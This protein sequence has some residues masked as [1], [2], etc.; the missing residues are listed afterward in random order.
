MS[1]K[2]YNVGI[3]ARVSKEDKCSNDNSSIEN[4]VS[5]L[6]S[7]ISRMP[8]WTPARIYID[9]GASGATFDRRGFR[10][11][12]ADVR[13]SAINLVLVKD[14]SRFGRNYLETGRYLEEELPALGCRFVAISDNIDTADGENDILPFLNAI[15]DFYIKDTSNRIKSVLT[16]KALDG[17]KLS[18]T[19]PYGYERNPN[20]RTRLV[21]DDAAAKIVHHIFELRA[22]G[23]GYAAIAR[24]LNKNSILSPRAHY[25]QKQG[26]ENR[27]APKTT[28]ACSVMWAAGTVK[29]IL[30]NELYIGNTIA[31][32][33]KTRSYRDSRDIK[34]HE[35]EWIRTED[36][37]EAII[38]RELWDKV[39][40]INQAAKDK[41]AKARPPHP[42]LFSRLLV[43]PDC[44]TKMVKQSGSY[45]CSTYQRSGKAVCSSHRISERN[46]KQLVIDDV[47]SMAAQIELD[48]NAILE[49]LQIK[50]IGA[51]RANSRNTAQE[52]KQLEQKIYALELEIEQLFEDKFEGAISL[53]EFAE[54]INLIESKR[55][56]AE[57]KL[58]TLNQGALQ[59][60]S[61]LDGIDKW[62]ALIKEK[63]ASPEAD[64]QM[65]EIL[66][67]KIEIGERS[68]EKLNGQAIKEVK[69]FY[70]FVGLCYTILQSGQ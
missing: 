5:M 35:S 16:T 28:A 36:T 41:S 11:M 27:A 64:R 1:R 57:E 48:E 3:Y 68:D 47:K 58:I 42:A 50:L 22:Q 45:D 8:N 4:Q 67:E 26:R 44:G 38:E 63:S 53:E 59:K 23:M 61:K 33:R 54:K 2:I 32:K 40:A 21:I 43:C 6:S 19:C 51:S 30:H 49:K 46:L 29:L 62:I 55:V 24:T 15:N 56:A 69:I 17:Q 70:N 52:R 9:E 14:L 66:I 25:F 10:D 34:R 31:F 37:H 60:Q 18:G 39:Q 13:S 7:F 65:L 12:M 20:E